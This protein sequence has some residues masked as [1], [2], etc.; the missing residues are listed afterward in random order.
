MT[1]QAVVLRSIAYKVKRCVSVSGMA[2]IY[3]VL[4]DRLVDR[5]TKG[6]FG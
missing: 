4:V 5:R 3:G 6:G 1:L 2:K